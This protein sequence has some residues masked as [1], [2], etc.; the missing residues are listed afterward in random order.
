MINVL[1]CSD[2]NSKIFELEKQLSDLEDKIFKNDVVIKDESLK[3]K[4]KQSLEETLQQS[5]KETIKITDLKNYEDPRINELENKYMTDIE[6]I[7]KLNEIT[8]QRITALENNT[9]TV[10]RLTGLSKAYTHVEKN[11]KRITDLETNYKHNYEKLSKRITEL[12][13]LLKTNY[14]AKEKLTDIEKLNEFR[15]ELISQF[16]NKEDQNNLKSKVEKLD[17]LLQ[18]SAH[19]IES[20]NTNLIALKK[21]KLNES[22]L[23]SQFVNKED[24]NI[25]KTKVDRIENL[26]QILSHSVESLSTEFLALR[27]VKAKN[28]LDVIQLGKDLELFK[29]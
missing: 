24:Q 20:L 7:I 22:E 25:L 1:M 16:V 8:T 26:L 9:K 13:N 29:K 6:K 5:L 15:T 23:V 21:D 2:N 28:K 10:E 18:T 17:N 3:E 14:I 4:L 11:S 27:S 19:S 12:E